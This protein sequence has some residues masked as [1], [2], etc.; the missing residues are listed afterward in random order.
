MKPQF[1]KFLYL[2]QKRDGYGAFPTII[3]FPPDDN[4]ILDMLWV[5]TGIFSLV[6][7]VWVHV[8]KLQMRQSYWHG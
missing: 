7:E 4:K 3:P 8:T 1:P 5:L 2:I 6:K